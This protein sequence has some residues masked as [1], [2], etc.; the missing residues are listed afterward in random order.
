MAFEKKKIQID[1]LGEYILEIRKSLNLKIKQISGK[2][3]ISEKFIEN[4]ELGNFG[5]LPA[6]VY[7]L[8]FLRQLALEY[9]IDSRQL[10]DQYKK[11]KSIFRHLQDK[12]KA[13]PKTRYEKIFSKIIITPKILSLFFGLLFVGVTIFY[14][15]WQVASLSRSPV[16]EIFTPNQGQVFQ[17][18]FVAV[19]GKTD[20][21]S[22]VTVNDQ[23][24]FVDESG[25]FQTQI[26]VN[27]G[28][29]DISVI[30]KN[31]FEKTT[32]KIVGI[33]V[34]LKNGQAEV[35]VELSLSF[36]DEVDLNISMDDNRAI[37]QVFYKGDS[38][39][40]NAKNKIVIST[41]NAG[42]TVAELNGQKIGPLGRNGEVLKNVPF[43]AE[44]GNINV[45]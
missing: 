13:E 28:P 44:N 21:G 3:G 30:A 38:K 29:K 35:G 23:Q 17:T 1:T 37:E 15:I 9:G 36:T 5:E 32:K 19:K 6:D 16:L 27:S 41:S 12:E 25:I 18:S 8:G 22:L 2:T 40:F 7:V 11:E 4:L 10:T 31:K 26:G 24:V 34:E 20:I 39:I 33:N 43:F 45:K 42:A 14:I